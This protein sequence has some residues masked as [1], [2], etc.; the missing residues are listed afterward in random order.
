MTALGRVE[1]IRIRSPRG[2]G[3]WSS[4]LEAKLDTGADWSRIGAEQ[5]ADLRLGPILKVHVITTSS[6]AKENRVRVPARVLI[7]GVDVHTHFVVST[8][9]ENVI[10]G[11]NTRK[12]LSQQSRFRIDP[13]RKHLGKTGRAKQTER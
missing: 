12:E 13:T 5:A 3:K 2:R 8:G 7:N 11:L 6:G 9:K 10:I 1:W 4:P